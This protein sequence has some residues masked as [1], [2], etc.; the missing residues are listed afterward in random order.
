M[1]LAELVM[2]N[3]PRKKKTTRRRKTAKAKKT[4][5][6]NTMA[7]RRTTR[8][9]A[10]S[11]RRKA[12]PARRKTTRR[13]STSRRR[14]TTT[15]RRKA[16]PARRRTTR[17][18]KTTRRK[19]ARRKATTRRRKATTR[20]RKPARRRK[21]TRRRKPARRRSTS[22]RRKT[23]RRRKPA[24][25]RRTVRRRST[26]RRSP[27]RRRKASRRRTVRSRR[28]KGGSKRFNMKNAY[29]WVTN[30]LTAFEAIVATV[31]GM[32][33]GGAM[34]GLVQSGL[35]RVG[36]PSRYINWM[37]SGSYTPYIAGAATGAL[38]AFALHSLL[39]VKASTASAVALGAVAIQAY[40]LAEAQGVFSSLKNLIGLGG[41][42]HGY[43][44]NV[45]MMDMD[46]SLEGNH[47]GAAMT[48]GTMGQPDEMLFGG[49]RQ[50]NF[51]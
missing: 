1:A 10:T 24:S 22:R 21:T 34:P 28:S 15:R 31:G 37:T 20:R 46:M 25:R 51:Y 19:P 16:S 8:R 38:G 30:H 29:K 40:R 39:G 27:A 32:F 33:L 45:D 17:R 5:R 4:N 23:T 35:S 7:R 47:F 13:K 36:V 48:Y 42:N 18:R 12:T 50:M 14:K 11:R 2:V 9:K 44:G 49:S 6:G 26:A 41:Y 43:L 3:P